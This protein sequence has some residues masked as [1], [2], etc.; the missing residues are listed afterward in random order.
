MA[1]IMKYLVVS[2]D[3][4]DASQEFHRE[5]EFARLLNR[6]TATRLTP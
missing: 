5:D 2:V 6:L 1:E 3:A 4:I